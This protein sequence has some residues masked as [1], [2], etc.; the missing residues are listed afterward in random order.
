MFRDIC[1][2]ITCVC[3][4]LIAVLV[5]VS[6]GWLSYFLDWIMFWVKTS[7]SLISL[8]GLDFLVAWIFHLPLRISLYFTQGIVDFLLIGML[9]F[10][11][12]FFTLGV[13][14]IGTRNCLR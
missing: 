5:S 12:A 4:T 1:M 9:Y 13:V 10:F 7:L 14:T 3:M 11:S 2:L 8:I 6:L